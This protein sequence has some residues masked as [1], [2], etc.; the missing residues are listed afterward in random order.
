VGGKENSKASQ[1][2]I[3]VMTRV[4]R[5]GQDF[6]EGDIRMSDLSMKGKPADRQR[7]FDFARRLLVPLTF[8]I[9]LTPATPQDTS[10]PPDV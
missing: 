8:M 4:L 1:A 9:V 5:T 10:P 3:F 2:F 6:R 7:N